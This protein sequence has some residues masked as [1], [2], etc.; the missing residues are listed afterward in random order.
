MVADAPLDVPDVACDEAPPEK[1]NTEIVASLQT[2]EFRQG[3]IQNK[4]A[5]PQRLKT[6]TFRPKKIG[7]FP[8]TC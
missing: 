8:L 3:K 4:P 7:V 5:Q 2:L 1:L 6:C